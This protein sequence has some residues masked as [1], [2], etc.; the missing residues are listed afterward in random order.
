MLRSVRQVLA[1]AKGTADTCQYGVHIP[2]SLDVKAIRRKVCM[3]QEES[4][5]HFGVDKRSPLPR[6]RNEC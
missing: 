6:R 4:A 5:R 1:Y 2:E 3:S